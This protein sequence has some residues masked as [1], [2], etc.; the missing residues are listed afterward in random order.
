MGS[1]SI[2]DAC[3]GRHGSGLLCIVV[4]Q[5]QGPREK[6]QM[7][8]GSLIS[9]TVRDSSSVGCGREAHLPVEQRSG[10]E[11]SWGS[12]RRALGGGSCSRGRVALR[13]ITLVGMV[14]RAAD[15]R[16]S[17]GMDA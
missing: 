3:M 11:F 10:A 8:L 13:C 4:R 5:L 15:S 6:F 1:S 17:D 16:L 7:A 12:Q 14:L 2:R 9:F